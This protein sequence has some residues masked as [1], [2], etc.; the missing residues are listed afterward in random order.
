MLS[1]MTQ[2]WDTAQVQVLGGRGGATSTFAVLPQHAD[3][4]L[5]LN[6]ENVLTCF[7]LAL[8]ILLNTSPLCT[9]G[10]QP[11]TERVRQSSRERSVLVPMVLA[12]SIDNRQ[13]HCLS[14][15]RLHWMCQWKWAAPHQGNVKKTETE[16]N[17]KTIYD[18][19]A[20]QPPGCSFTVVRFKTQIK[21]HKF[22][23][24]F[25]CLFVLGIE[26]VNQC[27]KTTL[28]WM[29]LCASVETWLGKKTKN[30]FTGEI[31]LRFPLRN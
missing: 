14:K 17:K 6:M 16:P 3:I 22:S 29:F 24:R 2:S 12:V 26:G 11:H 7:F 30:W 20:H 21:W 18:N 19:D 13:R 27:K 28:V 8:R 15:I 1:D 23:T 9:R 5:E 10:L 31:T 25:K 4:K